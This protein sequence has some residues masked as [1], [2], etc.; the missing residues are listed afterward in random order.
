MTSLAGGCSLLEEEHP[1]SDAL[2]LELVRPLLEADLTGALAGRND[3]VV[4]Y[5]AAWQSSRLRLLAHLLE[6][7]PELR[8]PP[9]L[10]ESL[11]TQLLHAPF[12]AWT[13]SYGP[14]QGP[15]LDLLARLRSL[16]EPQSRPLPVPLSSEKLPEL[17]R[18]FDPAV[19]RRFYR[20]ALAAFE[21]RG[22]QAA[23]IMDAFGLNK[24]E[25]GR[26][27]GVS[28][29]AVDQWLGGEVPADRR[30]K[31]AVVLAIIDLIEPRIKAGRLSGI[32]RRRAAAYGERSMLE[33]IE[34][35]DEEQLLELTRRSFDY[36]TTA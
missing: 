10:E 22:T 6:S 31:A 23:Q 19:T 5:V 27:F 15:A 1:D 33:M 2:F 16:L 11:D 4:A 35:D 13:A 36:A 20:A 12:S 24:S 25:L 34:A 30:A 8:L 21:G 7:C 14:R 3:A 32:A 18:T 17:W 28:R 9:L 29:Q 26:M